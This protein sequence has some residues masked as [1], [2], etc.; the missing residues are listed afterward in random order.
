MPKM[1][2][3][4]K[5]F[6]KRQTMN[7]LLLIKDSLWNVKMNLKSCTPKNKTE[8]LLLSYTKNTDTHSEQTR[9]KQQELMVNEN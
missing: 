6:L 4:V 3:K 8:Y 7:F 5:L 2:R 9:T 1:V